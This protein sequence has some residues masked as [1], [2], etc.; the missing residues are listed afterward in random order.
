MVMKNKKQ[1]ESQAEKTEDYTEISFDKKRLVVKG[2]N[3]VADA[4]GS[5]LGA[6]GR[7][8]MINKPNRVL[9]TKDGVTVAESIRLKN[10]Y[11][12]CGAS[13]SIEA[14]QKTA[15]Q[16]GDGTTTT[17][18]LT[19]AILNKLV[20]L[21]ETRN[22]YKV[23]EGMIQAIKDVQKEIDS[24]KHKVDLDYIY[25][26]AFTASNNNEEI[27]TSIRD[28]YKSLPTW[29]IDILFYESE[30]QKDLV[31]V[32]NGYELTYAA[33]DLKH[34]KVISDAKIVL[35]DYKVTALGIHLGKAAITY[36]GETKQPLIFICR[37]YTSD[38][39]DDLKKQS[40]LYQVNL[41]CVK[42]DL[43]GKD[44]SNQ[45][46]DLSYALSADVIEEPLTDGISK[47]E[48][49]EYYLG[50]A[51]SVTLNMHNTLIA[52]EESVPEKIQEL[53]GLMDETLDPMEKISIHKR[54]QKLKA[55]V[56]NYYVGGNTPQEM[57]ERFYRIEDS[58]MA[59]STAYRHGIIKGGGV[60]YLEIA[61]KLQSNNN[62]ESDFDKGYQI[63]LNSLQEPFNTM[64]HNSFISQE[65]RTEIY[66]KLKSTNFNSIYNFSSNGFESDSDVSIYD[67]ARTIVVALEAAISV[68]STIFLTSTIIL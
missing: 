20:E 5:T 36:C 45:I 60:P 35:L 59:C 48:F 23:K 58:V 44:A 33:A 65:L 43:Y 30:Y 31:T 6:S 17:T 50:K 9:V 51:K 63:V 34:R 28:I 27:A 52:F 64:C 53:E 7:L 37:D 21:E 39:L 49:M 8:V 18:I 66:E 13:L 22:F 16:V 42:L 14:A 46:S 38:F 1:R 56:A 57:K 61:M 29:D 11:E 3:L 24:M 68:A 47:A 19:R 67:T 62:S 2:V 4:V 40:E 26:I 12:N 25:K 32:E 10:P 55:C 41:Y 54:L 15:K